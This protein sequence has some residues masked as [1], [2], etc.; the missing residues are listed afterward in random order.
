VSGL[1]EVG[2]ALK[3]K[4]TFGFLPMAESGIGT[5]EAGEVQAQL[6]NVGDIT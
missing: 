4:P 3:R 5:E 1:W 6:S 2:E